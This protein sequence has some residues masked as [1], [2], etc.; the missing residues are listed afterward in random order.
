M[1]LS[2]CSKNGAIKEQHLLFG[3]CESRFGDLFES[4]IG[5]LFLQGNIKFLANYLTSG[6]LLPQSA[7]V[8]QHSR[9]A[10][11]PCLVMRM[12]Y[13]VLAISRPLS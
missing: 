3:A 7:V 9:V 13:S 8:K 12:Q 1:L 5:K 4:T 10:A 2:A 6:A 11:K